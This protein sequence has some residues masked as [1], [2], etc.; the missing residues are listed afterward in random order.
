MTHA[1]PDPVQLLEQARREEAA[2]TRGRLKIFLGMAPGVGKTYAM[3]SAARRIARDGVDVVAGIVETHGRAETEEILLGLDLLPRRKVE[4]R[5]VQL[6]E[7]DLDAALARRPEVLLVDELAH[8]NV[9]GPG[10]KFEKR[11]QDVHEC[12]S[13][14]IDVFTTLNVQHIESLNDVVAQ[15]T[16]VKVTET[17]PDSVVDQADEIEL[18][19]LPPDALIERLRAGKVY[20]AENARRAVDPADGFFR[21]GNLAALRELAL[22]RTASWVDAQMRQ[23]KADRGIRA[24]W[25][26]GERIIVAVSPS[27]MSAKL[28]R[29]AKRMAAGL[30][31][32]LLAVYVQTPRTQNL[33]QA[34][35]ERV[36]ETLRLAESLGA[37]T[38]TLEAHDAAKELI[39]FARSRNV[40]R[41]V[42]GKTERSRLRDALFGSFV[43]NLI[44]S[45]GDIDIYVIRGE[46]GESVEPGSGSAVI[47]RA[48]RGGARALSG[49]YGAA[50]LI[51][52]AI[53]LACGAVFSRLELANIAMVYLA[54]VVIAAARLGRGP[55]VL[56]AVL[57]VASL[58]FFFVTPRGSFA[59]SDVQYLL[60]FAVMLGVGLLI[61]GLTTRLRELAASARDREQ[62]TSMLYALSR[63]LAAAQ[64]AHQVSTVAARHVHD[65]FHA[66]AVIAVLSNGPAGPMLEP[67]AFAGQPDWFDT[68]EQGV[69]RWAIEHGKSAGLGTVR[70]PAAAAR[71]TPLRGAAGRA[72]VLAVRP[73][74]AAD[75][76]ETPQLLLLDTFSSQIA[77]ALERVALIEGQQTARLE[78]RTERLR[79]ALLSSVSH[80][81]R[82]PL[83][84]IAG[85]ASTLEQGHDTLDAS[86][87]LGLTRGIVQESRRL[88]DLIANLVFATRLDA[89]GI[90]LHRDWTTVEEIVGVGLARHRDALA[91]RPFR[92]SIP[93]QLPLLRVD[94]A[95]LPQVIDNLVDNAL[96]HTPAGTP[97]SIDAWSTGA[98]LVVRV[99]DEGPGLPDEELSRVFLRFYRGRS[100]RS[101]GEASLPAASRVG[102]GLGLTICEGI[103][104]AH[105]GRIWAERNAPRGVAFM[106]SLPVEHP[107][108][109]PP[110]EVVE[111][112]S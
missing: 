4:Y 2:A 96:A 9:P 32:D 98:H 111:A 31:A 5:G 108:P 76:L 78:A 101:D 52:V 92:V 23:Y 85:A 105:Q 25:P 77:S 109:G 43:G 36:V 71:Y 51:V 15:I 106:F 7:F 26:A 79:S 80:D 30:H 1:R 91:A 17:V 24:V 38:S 110:P 18:V 27:P 14:G 46:T 100:P 68:R 22:R 87:R 104:K 57:G 11:W 3:L 75:V 37:H 13:R 88:S 62:R 8:T 90:T 41:I 42:V 6:E 95:M 53:S 47:P 112:A 60:T 102:M 28:V 103:I 64:D 66:D 44:R 50:V 10:G 58:D 73:R 35:R 40:S 99:A 33:P 94:N 34:D 72:G 49:R 59:V 74:E 61:A 82:T 45:S 48:R 56:A 65:A 20:Q 16:G 93:T 21:K 63:D 55:A 54:G 86:T 70:L 29:A 107:Q 12:L 83:A 39:A 97:I 81:L 19:D 67:L 89:G 84:S 69:A